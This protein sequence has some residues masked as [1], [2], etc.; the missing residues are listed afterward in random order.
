MKENGKKVSIYLKK[1]QGKQTL[2]TYEANAKST[3][4]TRNQYLL[5]DLAPVELKY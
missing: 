3:I 1:I 5:S 4:H 2:P